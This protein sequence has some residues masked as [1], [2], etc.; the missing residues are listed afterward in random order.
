MEKDL[1]SLEDGLDLNQ[2][3]S[4]ENKVLERGDSL[5]LGDVCEAIQ[6]QK[7]WYNTFIF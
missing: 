5:C 4:V 1:G 3:Q 2:I 6:T 7:I